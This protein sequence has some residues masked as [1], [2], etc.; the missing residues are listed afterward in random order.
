[1]RTRIQ[2]GRS[3]STAISSHLS[4][5]ICFSPLK[6]RCYRGFRL[7]GNAKGQAASVWFERVQPGGVL[8]LHLL[9]R[10]SSA[11]KV[12][13]LLKLMLNSLQP[14]TPLS[15]SNLHICP[16]PAVTPKLLI[17]LLNTSDLHPETPNLVLKNS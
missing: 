13:E 5:L 1:M 15:V 11:A 7:C 10:N 16:N 8:L 14:L 6:R 9:C 12:C 2:R 3:T 4:M 17:Q